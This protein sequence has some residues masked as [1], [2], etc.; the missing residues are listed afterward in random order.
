METI[1][2][3]VDPKLG[4]VNKVLT[5]LKEPLQA[6]E[7]I[8]FSESGR[9]SGHEG[10]RRRETPI[11]RLKKEVC[12]MKS[13]VKAM[14]NQNQMLMGIIKSRKVISAK[15]PK[16]TYMKDVPKPMLCD[17]KDKRTIE[18]LVN[19]YEAYCDASRYI[20][21]EVRV[22]SFGSFLK[23]GASIS[24]GAWRSGRAEDFA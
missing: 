5:L 15:G 11:A 10:L 12:K 7:E 20:G 13:V 19:K 17:T 22:R 9:Y 14:A 3:E 16:P 18:T 8:S 2:V 23:D 4:V 21:N 6:R 24:F 1:H